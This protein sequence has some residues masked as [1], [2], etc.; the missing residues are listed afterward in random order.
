MDGHSSTRV[1]TDL[2]GAV[3][4]MA[5][6]AQV[7]HY[8]AY[9]NALNFNMSNAA[10]QY[11]YSGE[12]FDA[13]IQQQYLR[14]RY[15]NQANGTFNRLDPFFG[16]LSDP[17]SLHKYLYTHADPI[18]GIDPTGLEFSLGGLQAAISVGISFVGTL[19]TALG[20]VFTAY[21]A[22]L[23]IWDIITIVNDVSTGG[24]IL[25]QAK[26]AVDNFMKSLLTSAVADVVALFDKQFWEESAVSFGRNSFKVE[27]EL[28][29]AGL[30][31]LEEL[32]KAM[33]KAGSKKLPKLI[34]MLP[35]PYSLASAIP[36]SVTDVPGV[37]LRIGP[38]SVTLAIQIGSASGQAGR[39]IGFAVQTET[40][41]SSQ[42]W[43]F[44]QDYHD[45]HIL[46]GPA[47]DVRWKDST[48][49]KY[50]FHYHVNKQ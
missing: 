3:F 10:T 23:T 28:F 8:D 22:V 45:W 18:S 26:K 27:S 49:G 24:P 29:G 14:A 21:N 19:L 25:T 20:N 33:K 12:Q 7:F 35:H 41:D 9:G 4:T 38:M 13:R 39:V 16:N 32:I 42:R 17:Q 37:K 46:T 1:L 36:K 6:L 15:Y 40:N 34:V 44:R 30:S 50:N 43:L 48:N 5:G 31:L 47:K 2:A 11:L